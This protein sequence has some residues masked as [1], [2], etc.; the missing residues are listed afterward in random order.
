MH[1]HRTV[2]QSRTRSRASAVAAAV[3]L[4]SASGSLA[5]EVSSALYLPC[6]S[7]EG[8]ASFVA[9]LRYED[10]GGGT[11]SI[12]I[13]LTNTTSPT[14]GGYVT[15]I[16]LNAIAGAYDLSFVSSTDADFLVTPSPVDASPYG[17][18][19]AG[20][21]LGGDWLG[22]G[23]PEDGIGVGQSVRFE[24]TITGSREFLK[25]LDAETVLDHSTDAMAVRFRGGV[26]GW[27]DK[28]VG[29]A[30]SPGGISALLIG[31]IVGV[32]RRRR[33]TGAARPSVHASK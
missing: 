33:S 20:A 31:P 23:F 16:A 7:T 30:P 4:A 2:S 1:R 8:I 10:L 5:C 27:S 12:T 18:F 17:H 13:D 3:V 28:V 32:G 24:F 22:G 25:D 21:A 26:G 11:A 6:G 14:L 29:C 15:G 9:K 19:M